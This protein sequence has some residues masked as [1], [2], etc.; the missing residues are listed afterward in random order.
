MK[1]I[2]LLITVLAIAVGLYE[3]S[4]AQP[5]VIILAGTIAV[6]MYGLMKLSAKVPSKHSETEEEHDAER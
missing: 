4:K 5:N 1:K 6:L 2:F 3:Q